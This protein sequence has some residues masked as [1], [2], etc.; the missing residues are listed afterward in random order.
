M[1]ARVD[2]N[3]FSLNAFYRNRLVRCY[4]GATRFA[5]RRAQ[6]AELHRLRRQR[7]S[8]AGRLVERAAAPGPLH[9]V[10]CALNLGG[11]SDL[12]LHTRHSAAFTLTPFRCGSAYCS[13][14]QS[15]E[16]EELGYVPTQSIRRPAGAP[17]LG[18]AIAVSGAAASPNMGYHT[19]PVVAFLLTLFNVR[20]G[21]WFPNPADAGDGYPSPRFNLRYLV[22]ELFGGAADKSTV[23]DDLRRRALRE[24]RRLRAGP[25]P[26][27]RHH[28]QRRRM[29]SEADLRRAG[30]ADPHVRG[31]LRRQDHDRRRRHPRRLRTSPW[32]TRRLAV[33]ASGTA[34]AAPDG[35]LIYLKASMTGREDTSVLQYK[36]SHPT[37]P[38]ETTGDQFYGEDQFESYRHLGR[39]D[40]ARGVWTAS[41]IAGGS[42]KAGQG[43]PDGPWRRGVRMMHAGIVVT[44]VY[45]RAR[46]VP[47][48]GRGR[49]RETLRQDLLVV[50][51]SVMEHS[52]HAWQRWRQAI[53]ISTSWVS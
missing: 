19:S 3:E 5:P 10:N 7:R 17:T 23:R 31:G 50:R 33:G 8:A 36:A 1:A 15:G 20:L 41:S 49:R 48:V 2:I 30:H 27:P 16:A 40:R 4:L 12:A 25:A 45:G 46:N 29:R 39:D 9:I 35:I 44:I 13:R 47:F 38:H 6:A 11:S 32:S 24:P 21:W 14:D 42:E 26:V 53:T 51:R 22:A 52:G 18:Q 37:F 28:H 43:S 34:A